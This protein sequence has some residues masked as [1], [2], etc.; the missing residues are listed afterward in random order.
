MEPGNAQLTMTVLMTPDMANFSGNVHGGT[1]LK[2]LDE[3][4]YACASRYA[5]RYVVTL[6]VDQVVFRQPVHVGEL[7]TFLASVNYTGTT[8]MEIGIKVITENIRERSVRHTNSCFFTMVALDDERR[9]A[10]VPPLE[11]QT[12]DQKRRY[13]QGQ[14][15]RE[16]RQELE[17]RYRALRGEDDVQG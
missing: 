2:Y 9:P 4:A 14:Q 17:R 15:R 5:G 16:I 7:V 13:V 3:V 12:P 10:P 11:P 8:S 1:L 6:S